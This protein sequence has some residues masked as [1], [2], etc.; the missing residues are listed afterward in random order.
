MLAG[1]FLHGG[2]DMKLFLAAVLCTLSTAAS[3]LDTGDTRSDYAT[4]KAPDGRAQIPPID[5]PMLRFHS[6]GSERVNQGGYGH[7]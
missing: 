3:S 7:P 2:Q 1:E 5:Y 6:P 4:T